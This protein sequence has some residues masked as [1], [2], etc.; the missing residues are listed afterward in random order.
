[1]ASDALLLERL[2]GA[3]EKCALEA[4]VVGSVAAILQGAPVMTQD[5][6]LLVRDTPLN[7]KKLDRLGA[8]LGRGRPVPVSELT[9]AVTLLG[10]DMPL[11]FLFDS[12][13]GGLSF[14]KLRSRCLRIQVGKRTALVARLE[15]VIRSKESAG[16]LKDQAQLPILRDTLRVKQALDESAK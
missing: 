8:L 15:D 13:S 10:A 14:A 7:R 11:D 3:L 6:D 4:I 9:S 2:F 5:V 16:R 12:I 1:M